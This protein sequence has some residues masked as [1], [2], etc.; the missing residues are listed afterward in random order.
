MVQAKVSF[1]LK[2]IKRMS[3]ADQ[4]HGCATEQTLPRKLVFPHTKKTSSIAN[5]KS[6]TGAPNAEAIPAAA[7]AEIN[8]LLSSEFLNLEKKGSV[9][10]IDADLNCD[11]PAA[12]RLP[13]LFDGPVIVEE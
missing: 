6:Q 3:L 1:I 5:N 9:H 7:P 12:T 4:L 2:T 8:F 11:T 13:F 10:S